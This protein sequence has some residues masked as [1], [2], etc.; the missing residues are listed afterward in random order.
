V[1]VA[2]VSAGAAGQ[3]QQVQNGQQLD[4]NPAV[5]RAG[6]NTPLP[7]NSQVNSQLYVTGQVSGLARFRD[8]VGY[9]A[10]GQLDLVLPSA[11]MDDFNR[12]GTGITDATRNRPYLLQ[13]YYDPAK[14]TMYLSRALDNQAS[15]MNL[16]AIATSVPTAISQQLYVDAMAK[17]GAISAS[18]EPRPTMSIRNDTTLGGRVVA[19]GESLSVQPTPS[20]QAAGPGF[21]GLFAVP[22]SNGQLDL[23]REL[24][25]A[26]H[27]GD[28]VNSR[29]RAEIGGQEFATEAA[30]QADSLAAL[31]AAGGTGT[32]GTQD[33][34]ARTRGGPPG[35]QPGQGPIN[36]DVFLDVL[37]K[38][39]QVR[40]QKAA[41]PTSAPAARQP[42]GTAP[43]VAPG[44]APGAS[45]A[46]LS[47]RKGLVDIGKDKAVVIHGL[48][49]LSKDLFNMNMVR[50]GEE[51][52]AHKYYDAAQMYET[53]SLVDRRNPLAHVGMG[54]GL[55][56]AGES[57]SAAYQLSQAITMF[58]PLMETRFDLPG[59]VDPKVIQA[60]LD[61]L[62][63]RIAAA[64]PESKRM[65]QFLAMFLYRNS[66]EP[67][68]A[69]TYAEQL[70]TTSRN[71]AILRAYADLI[72]T[73][74][75]PGE[76]EGVGRPQA[77]PSSLK[78]QPLPGGR[79]P[80]SQPAKLP[81]LLD[82]VRPPAGGATDKDA[83]VL[84]PA[85]GAAK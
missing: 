8:P 51:M 81:P 65:L 64:D 42:E 59:M 9:V 61:R 17:Y 62:D 39:R 76:T 43:G 5:G 69:R 20:D 40:E 29:V 14:T 37:M 6:Y 60:Q 28:M 57:L 80:A 84:K 63:S 47:G 19:S 50:A 73:G 27:R 85:A 4:A 66:S 33:L 83:K 11:E 13:P 77:E 32:S 3:V 1:V 38:M 41:G 82:P 23:Q 15:G 12:R 24:Y 25:A 34:L 10:P 7:V 54:L 55:L 48:A 68:K 45:L 36:Q 75:G 26:A 44:V 21:S 72:L 78:V 30:A 18:P 46:P 49:G 74:K 31:A 22:R 56:G 79:I 67:S 35:A 70:L 58:P 52:Q 53:A 71:N 2:C 16:P